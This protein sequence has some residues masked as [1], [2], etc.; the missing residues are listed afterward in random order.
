MRAI[1]FTPDR[2]SHGRKDY[3]G[4]FL[5]EARAFARTNKIDPH[6]IVAVDVREKLPA[7]RTHVEAALGADSS[8]DL[9]AFFCHGLRSSVQLGHSLQ[10]INSL[11]EAI[12]GNASEH[13]VVAL[14]CCSTGAGPGVGGDGGF[15]DG[16]RDALC[17]AG[18]VHCVVNAHDNA[19]HT[20]RNPRVR[21]FRGEGSP[22]GGT[23]G[24]WIVA[25]RSPLWKAWCK[26]LQ[27]D[28]RL[29][30]PLLSTA[31]IHRELQQQDLV[32]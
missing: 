19:G 3:T 16:L 1:I 9:I 12:A 23:G 6:R 25:P 14:Y 20:T 8:N 27:G 5:P 30:Y 2:D 10:T 15:A 21:R 29:R 7:R 24:G 22:V 4:A 32:A 26:A 17:R 31:Q 28:L 13:V 18:A 11:A